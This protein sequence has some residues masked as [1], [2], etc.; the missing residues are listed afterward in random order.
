MRCFW[1]L[2][3]SSLRY[4]V[5][6]SQR[7]RCVSMISIKVYRDVGNYRIVR[8]NSKTHTDQHGN[9]MLFHIVCQYCIVAFNNN[10]VKL[11]QYFR[12]DNMWADCHMSPNV[13]LFDEKEMEYMH[14]SWVE[15]PFS[16]WLVYKIFE[17]MSKI[18]F[19]LQYPLICG[20]E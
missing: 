7:W 2:L 6:S 3:F 20:K 15:F 11:I 19:T 16:L 4:E 5:E 14:T 9:E 12:S 18:L 1:I 17:T 13:K 10:N 8:F